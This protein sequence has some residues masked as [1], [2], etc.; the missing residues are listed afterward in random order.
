VYFFEN[1]H[2]NVILKLFQDI[3]ESFKQQKLWSFYPKSIFVIATLQ[4]ME[5][6]PKTKLK[7]QINVFPW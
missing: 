4:V 3:L 2:R 6:I 1:S 7:I 5:F